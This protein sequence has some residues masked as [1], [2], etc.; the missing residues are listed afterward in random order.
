MR[1]K[2]N[3][4]PA[5]F[6]YEDSELLWETIRLSIPIKGFIQPP[7]TYVHRLGD[8]NNPMTG[9]KIRKRLD[10]VLMNQMYE[11]AIAYD[12]IAAE[13][14]VSRHEALR[15]I[16]NYRQKHDLPPRKTRVKTFYKRLSEDVA[17]V[18][19]LRNIGRKPQQVAEELDMDLRRVQKLFSKL[20]MEAYH[21]GKESKRSRKCDN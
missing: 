10:P 15:T 1:L 3:N 16:D 18:E 4:T 6:S 20:K 11:D 21:H 19:K 12:T 5:K 9:H 7:V 13:Y 17:A 8:T 2:S 14:G